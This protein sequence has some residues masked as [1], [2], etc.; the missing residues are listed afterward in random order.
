MWCS[1][2]HRSHSEKDDPNNYN[3]NIPYIFLGIAMVGVGLLIIFIQ[4]KRFK[5]GL[6]DPFGFE[7]SLLISGLGSIVIGIIVIVKNF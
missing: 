1:E 5:N 7:K 6:K 4:I 2:K 3:M